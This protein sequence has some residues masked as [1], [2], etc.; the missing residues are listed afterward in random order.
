MIEDNNESFSRR[1]TRRLN[2]IAI[3]STSPHNVLNELNAEDPN[4]FQD[5]LHAYR[6]GNSKQRHHILQM[7]AD[8]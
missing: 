4:L 7:T 3:W 8:I 1:I 6:A 5:L 2:A